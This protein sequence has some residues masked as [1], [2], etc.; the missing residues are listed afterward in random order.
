M[1]L[2]VYGDETHVY[3]TNRVT[4]G[5][6]S[7]PWH[8]IVAPKRVSLKIADRERK[9]AYSVI[10]NF[11][12]WQ[13]LTGG[14]YETWVEELTATLRMYLPDKVVDEVAKLLKKH[15]LKEA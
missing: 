3:K 9:K 7:A 5:V 12:N 14:T 15:L 2:Y 6:E 4:R 13:K 8:L 10:F 11:E 1:P